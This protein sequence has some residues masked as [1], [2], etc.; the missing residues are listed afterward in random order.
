M[1]LRGAPKPCDKPEAPFPYGIG[2]GKCILAAVE[3]VVRDFIGVVVVVVV[4][5][6]APPFRWAYALTTL[7]FTWAKREESLDES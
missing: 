1:L 4:A 6:G 3:E 7:C 5:V 2:S